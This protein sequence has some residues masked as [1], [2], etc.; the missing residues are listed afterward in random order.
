MNW[1]FDGD[2]GWDAFSSVG[3]DGMM[4]NWRIVVCEDGTFSVNESDGELT[5]RKETFDTLRDAKTWCAERDEELRLAC[6]RE[7]ASA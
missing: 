6:L 7:D 5:D 4:F 3:D 2:G 1:S